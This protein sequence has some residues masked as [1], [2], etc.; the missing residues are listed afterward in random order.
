MPVQRRRPARE[1]RDHGQRHRRVGNRHA[2]DGRGRRASAAAPGLDPVVAVA[3]VARPSGRARRRTRRRPGSSRR[4]TPVTRTGPPAITPAARKYDAAEASPSTWIVPGTRVAAP[5]RDPER[6]PAVAARSSTPKR[7]SRLVVIA[8]YG[9]EISSPTTSIE[10]AA[11]R[12]DASSGSAISSADRNWLDTSPRTATRSGADGASSSPG[13][14]ASG[15]K[16]GV[17]RDSGCRR[18]A[19]A[20]R[21]RGRRSAARASAARRR[22][23]SRRRPTPATAVSGRNAVPGVAE[24]QLRRA[25]RKRAAAARA[26]RNRGCRAARPRATPSVAS[27]SSIRSTSSASS[28][29]QTRVGPSASAASSSVR[30]EMLFDPGSATSPR[31]AA[32][33]ARSRNAGRAGVAG[34]ARRRS[35]RLRIASAV[36]ARVGPPGSAARA[37]RNAAGLAR[38]LPR[39]ARGAGA[40]SNTAASAAPSRGLEQRGHAIELRA[41][42]RDLGQQR[43]AIGERD[44]APHLRRTRRDAGEVAKAAGGEAEELLAVGAVAQRRRPAR[45]RAGAAGATPPRRPGRGRPAPACAGVAP[46]RVHS[47]PTRAIARGV[48]LGDRR[49]HDVAVAE[50]R[51]ERRGRARVLGAGDRMRRAR[52]ARTRVRERG[53]RRGDDVLLGAA[54][55]GDDR[56]R[57]DL[58]RDRGAAAPG[59]ARPASRAAPRRRRR[60]RAS[61]RR[62]ASRTRSMTPSAA[63]RRG[64]LGRGR[65][66]RPRATAPAAFSAS[67][68]EPP[69]S[70]TPTTTS[71]PTVGSCRVGVATVIGGGPAQDASAAPSAARKRWFSAGRPTVTRR[72]SRQAVV[73]DR[74][75]DDALPQQLLVDAAGVADPTSRKLACDGTQDKP[76]ARSPASSA[77]CPRG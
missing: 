11:P 22:A 41:I 19:C 49:Q 26:R 55:V 57:A 30:L 54:G 12:R 68:N 48:G 16:P 36:R 75:H 33:G 76:S 38:G 44:V 71:L 61:S 73:G 46:Q 13:R 45:T 31:A 28:S 51:G 72:H 8:T 2:V 5:G 58:R 25:H 63:R 4:P 34:L 59:T 6:R 3:D 64:W 65:R 15:G 39:P 62:R 67:A 40:W 52:S 17:A 43:V 9:L 14:I 66:R 7:A 18:R 53:A 20:A 56:R 32:A 42:G 27:A 1:Q 70:P 37:A 35:R 47:A 24:E 69:I 74:A 50:Q 29:P 60:A 21:R 10:S 77:A 23:R